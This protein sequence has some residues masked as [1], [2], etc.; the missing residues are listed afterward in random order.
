[1]FWHTIQADV[2]PVVF[3][4]SRMIS[5]GHLTHGVNISVLSSHSTS[6]KTHNSGYFSMDEL[7][8]I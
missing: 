4:T 3:H 2:L 7:C 8:C 1:M 5:D 6:M